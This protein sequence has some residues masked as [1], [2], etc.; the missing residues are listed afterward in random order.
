[1]RYVVHGAGAIGGAIGAKLHQAGRDVLLIA[2]GRQLDALQAHRL[3][4][5]TPEGDQRFA[6]GAV[7]SAREIQFTADDVVL[8]AMKSQDT[9][10]ALDEL[11]EIADRDM[12]VVCAQ[13][14]V[15]NERVALRRFER[16]CTGCSYMYRR[17]C[18]SRPSSRCSRHQRSVCSIS[19]ACRM[20]RTSMP[21][22]LQR[23]CAP[24]VLPHA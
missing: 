19:V 23:I 11:S 15:E 1:M 17:S 22:R 7:G 16:V 9:A 21:R 20:D 6:L 2:R 10:A 12:T 8:L 5:Q 24:R 4:L 13:N 14:G 3:T 18:W